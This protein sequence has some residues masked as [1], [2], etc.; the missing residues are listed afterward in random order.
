M[1]I[2]L[3]GSDLD[4]RDAVLIMHN[5]EIPVAIAPESVPL[6]QKS[7]IRVESIVNQNKAVYGINTGFGSLATVPVAKEDLKTL[8]DNLIRSHAVGV[9]EPLNEALVRGILLLRANTLCRGYSGVR[10]EVIETLLAA[11]NQNILPVVPEIGSLGASGDLAPLSHLILGLMGEGELLCKKKLSD[12]DIIPLSLQA[13]EGLGM[14]NGTPVMSSIGLECLSRMEILLNA[15]DVISALSIEAL[16]GS[17]QPY[18]E[19]LHRVR[20]HKGQIQVA[21]NLYELLDGSQNLLSHKDCSRVQDAYSLRCIPQVHG[22]S[23]D[24]WDYAEKTLMIEINSVTDNPLVFEED[25]ISGGNFHGQPVG[26]ALALLSI[27]AAELGSISERRQNRLLNPALSGLPA[28]LTLGSGL[29]SGLMIL[30]Y[31]SAALVAENR[32]LAHPAVL[33]SLPTS[34]DQE[35]HVSMATTQARNCLKIV[36]HVEKILS[37]ELLMAVQGLRL[38]FSSAHGKHSLSPKLEPIFEQLCQT[39]PE[40][41]SDRVFQ[42]DM[43]LALQFLRSGRLL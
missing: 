2:Y 18:R 37:H 1:T 17:N 40:I 4:W 23:R 13:K 31:T 42:K 10:L 12:Y 36:E 20:A 26:L 3:N 22:A 38:L 21:R 7:R 32:V 24:A 8:Q 34:A 9:G 25:V 11:L 35:D 16:L 33:D 43:Q 29:N 39:L 15:S 28:F 41:T 27:A 19:E 5:K 14:I 30:Q 6:I